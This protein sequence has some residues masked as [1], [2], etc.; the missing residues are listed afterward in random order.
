MAV[1]ILLT[2][3][4]YVKQ[5]TISMNTFM[6]IAVS[7]IAHPYSI[8]NKYETINLCSFNAG[9]AS[10]ALGQHETTVCLMSRLPG[11]YK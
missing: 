8:L 5:I 3:V 4:F 6:R 1:E 10:Q 7:P 9:P 2:F 11:H